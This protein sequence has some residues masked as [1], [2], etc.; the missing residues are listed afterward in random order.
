MPLNILVVDDSSVMR[1]I[2]IRCLGL[3]GL[4]IGEV[5]EASNGREALDALDDVEGDVDL[6]LVDLNMPVMSGDEMLRR[7]RANPKTAHIPLIIVSGQSGF[8]RP[9]A[10][11]GQAVAV[12]S[13]PFTPEA[14]RQAVAETTGVCHDRRTSSGAVRGD[15][16]DS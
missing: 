15:G 9:D 13:K 6:A 14:L 11:R 12:I 1:S 4:P 7:L 5:H 16:P 3:I 2:V 8:E 10:L